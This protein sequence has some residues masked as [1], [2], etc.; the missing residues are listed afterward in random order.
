[1]LYKMVLC[2]CVVA[3]TAFQA[4]ASKLGMSAV[5]ALCALFPPAECR[6]HDDSSVESRERA[7]ITV[8]DMSP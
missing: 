4:P 2:M 5:R 7:E 8:A 3:A 6:R 1:M